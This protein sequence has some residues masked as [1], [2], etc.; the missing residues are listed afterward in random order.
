MLS[1]DLRAVRSST[2]RDGITD[3]IAGL[4]LNPGCGPNEETPLG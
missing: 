3:E 1:G 4:P 2:S